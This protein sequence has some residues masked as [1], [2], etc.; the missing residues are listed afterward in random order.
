LSFDSVAEIYDETRVVPRWVLHKFYE[1]IL[2]KET[3]TNRDLVVLDAG[4]GTGR[5]VGPLLDFGVQLVGIDVSR[6][7]LE[8]MVERVREKH[9]GNQV[10]LI[11]SDVT[12]LPFK[13]GSFDMVISILVLPWLKKWKQA[14]LETKRVL[15]PG[16]SFIAASHDSPEFQNEKG[17]MFLELEFDT[18]RPKNFRLNIFKRAHAMYVTKKVFEHKVMRLLNRLLEDIMKL[19]SCESYLKRK[20]SSREAYAILWKETI[21]VSTI[22]DL[23][24]KR[25][26][27]L[28]GKLSTETFEKLK[29][30]LARWRVERMEE[31][32]LLETRR[33]FKFTIIKF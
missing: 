14:I 1:K 20:T 13:A 28:E 17:K 32:P 31:N 24:N 12:S 25:L 10:S 3:Q 30:E 33:G 9:G 2:G 15:K 18:L 4:V 21:S 29:F 11:R 5:T 22:S 6:S 27:S 19:Y 16:G 7:M 8:K 26:S 23:L